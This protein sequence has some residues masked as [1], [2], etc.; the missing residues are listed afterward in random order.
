MSNIGV[1]GMGRV[2]L[3]AAICFAEMG[4]CVVGLDNNKERVGQLRRGQAPFYEPGLAELLAE[5]HANGRLAFTTDYRIASRDS[6]F[7]FI[8]VNTLEG[9]DNCS[10]L[11]GVLMEVLSAT[12]H[13]RPIIVIKSTV[14]PGTTEALAAK[15]SGTL[16]HDAP[17]L[18]VNPEFL[19]EGTAI[20]DF[21]HP[22]R[23]VI[24]AY[25][26]D[27]GEALASLY[28]P[29][30]RP[31]MITQPTTAELIKHAANAYLATRLSFINEMSALCEALRADITE[32]SR[33]LGLDHRIGQH[34]L[35]AG[36]GYGGSC[37]P[38]NLASLTDTARR[39]GLQPTLL[40]A[41]AQVNQQQRQ[42][43]VRRLETLLGGLAGATVGV[44]GLAYKPDTDDVRESPALA[45]ISAL[46]ERG[47]RIQA[48]DPRA[49]PE[50]RPLLP[51]IVYC[52]S[53]YEAAQEA[54]ALLLA[55]AWPEFV[56]LD[57]A[58]IKP[59]M[60]RPVVMDGWN[61]W[62]PEPLHALGFCYIGVGRGNTQYAAPPLWAEAK[63]SCPIPCRPEENSSAYPKR[64]LAPSASTRPQIS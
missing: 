15:L 35:R 29:L 60:R 44:L 23:V 30:G 37:L 48:Y 43:L 2:G 38:R 19:R 46:Q 17:P 18:A 39:R 28:Q 63:S 26:Q 57:W 52:P 54:D 31:I 40:E 64:L 41:T 5:H 1:V 56:D 36:L 27:V 22:D 33:G 6:E 59:R 51:H 24:G 13:R 55:T 45:I 25:S 62:D 20:V 14:I 49:M 53:A 42:R 7:I 47:A 21:L 34:Y 9:D 8:A 32:V 11:A 16:N 58:A 4:H 50:A 61:L 10:S 12:A 3:V